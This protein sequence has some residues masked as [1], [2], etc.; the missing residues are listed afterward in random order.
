MVCICFWFTGW[1]LLKIHTIF[2]LKQIGMY[3][4]DLSRELYL[5]FTYQIEKNAFWYV[6]TG[7]PRPKG[8]AMTCMH[9][10]AS[11]RSQWRVELIATIFLRKSRN[12][13]IIDTRVKHEYDSVVVDTV[14]FSSSGSSRGR[15]WHKSTRSIILLLPKQNC[16]KLQYVFC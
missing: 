1:I 4:V 16:L 8:L 3:K 10:I 15:K 5:N 2:S 13:V 12:D 6:Y 9:W 7:L 11:L 14:R